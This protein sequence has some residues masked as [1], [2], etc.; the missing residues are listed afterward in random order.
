[1]RL[2]TTSDSLIHIFHAAALMLLLPLGLHAQSLFP[3]KKNK[4]WGLINSDGHIVRQPV[5]D[6]IGEFKQ[7]GYAIMQRNG[8]IG[9]LDKMGREV[10][11]P[12]Y[13]D[14][15][16]L[17]TA[18]VAVM[19]NGQWK[20][21]NMNGRTVLP[22]GYQQVEV[23]KGS[24]P[25]CLAYQLDGAWGIVDAEGRL[26]ASPQ[27]DKI[28]VLKNVPKHVKGFYFKTKKDNSW[29]VLLPSGR[30]ILAPC[31]DEIWVYNENLFF[32]K[33]NL[34]WGAVDRLG[35]NVLQPVYNHF[36]RLS[37]NFVKLGTPHGQAL[38]SLVYN[39]LVSQTPYDA[40][41]PFSPDYALCKK[42]RQLGLTGH[43]G[44][45]ALHTRYDEI[46]P[47]GSNT[48]RVSL[49]GQWGIVTLDD[50]VLI[51]FR[52]DYISPMKN[53]LCVIIKDHRSG[54]ANHRGQVLVPTEYD[55]IF[56]EDR[57]AK[58]YKGQQLSVFNF[59]NNG[60][61]QQQNSFN[62]HFTIN[63]VRNNDPVPPSWQ[64][65]QNPYQ[66]KKF[67]WFYS[68]K[69]DKWGLRRLDNGRVQIEPTFH[70]VRVEK[71]LGLTLV[72]I[73]RKQKLKFGQTSYRFEMTYG[74]VQNDTG[75]LVHEVDLLDIRLS[76]FDNGLPVARCIFTNGK[77][78][79]INRIGKVIRKDFT[80]VG[81][82]TEGL[83]RVGIKGKTS[84][85]LK[86]SPFTI[87]QLNQYLASQLPPVTLTDYTRY[88]YDM[89][90]L[91]Y[92][93]CDGCQW[94][95]VDTLGQLAV[96]PQ[97]DFARDFK[98]NVG[99]VATGNKWGMVNTK[100]KTLLRCEF[101]ELAFIDK[102]GNQVLH[103][104]K[105]EQKYGLIDTLG[106]LAVGVQYDEIGSFAEGRL[107]VKRRNLWGYVDANGLET[108]PCRFTQAGPFSEGLAA[109]RLGSK[110]GYID[111]N[112]NIE[113]PFQFTKAGPFRNGLAPAKK[114]GPRFGYIDPRGHWAI[115]PQYL[116]A[117]PFDRGV[118]RIV[119][120]QGDNYRHGLIN[121]KGQF[122]VRP[123]FA[124]ISPFDRHGLAVASLGGSPERFVLLNLNGEMVTSRSFRG[125]W[126]F[127][128]GLAKVKK[129]T[130]YGFINTKGQLVIPAKFTK[131]TDFSEGRAA[132]W[133]NGR[134][135]FIDTDGHIVINTE[136]SRC[137]DFKDGKAIVFKGNQRA[138]LIDKNGN[139]FIEPGI[140][141]LLEF[142]E[143]RGLVR[144]KHY[145]CYYITEQAR[146]YNGYYDKAGQ[147]QH[148]IAVVQI[149]GRWAIINQQGIKI[150]PPKYD[151]I[152]QFENGFAKVRIKG[153]NGLSNTRGE[154]IV[155]PDYEYISYAGE[156]LFRVE[157]GDKIG[158]FD[159]LGKW[160][161]G[162]Q[163]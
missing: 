123:K 69:Q 132:I 82:F 118:A 163:D 20:V 61:L 12:R 104:F 6:A 45:Q 53:G 52:Y 111:K 79:L 28:E 81:T 16:V 161:W 91:G 59:D 78:G 138:G 74:L 5:Y 41:Y 72:G 120:L 146:F 38:F 11:P 96:P 55:R 121:S 92:L 129:K 4:K 127:S 112:G 152:E 94:G 33:K 159:M 1:M 9:M 42:G 113:L 2:N 35:Q 160:V 77:H 64:S 108:V 32:Y 84:C 103:I 109:V 27:Y 133:L 87:G 154:L 49:N 86:N 62:K 125:I 25:P 128:D 58:A 98:N 117:N 67:E 141:Q 30:E 75:L 21:L 114:E 144:D 66:L 126:P 139:F 101:D 80:Y 149:N 60:S 31:A 150:I 24:R 97:Y 142:T 17:D 151:K 131:A 107:A 119:Q 51:P 130:G 73:E 36:S 99:I 135:G 34:K 76:D 65:D 46:Q 19:K 155:Q 50:V 124:S 147:F 39:Q 143:G 162:L 7:Y 68:P 100:G 43:C 29:G 136:F 15:K 89:D 26:I 90:R 56:L 122:V 106:Q 13:Q 10:V 22:P 40:I 140:N 23:L 47:Y 93:T 37:D 116:Q 148:G 71:N 137:M 83:A 153:F 48:F 110:W 102:T 57:L 3:I 105:K 115:P 158:Y 85:S 88:D 8:R 157:Q 44:E 95:Y 145:K 70:E 134:C 18:L 54:V 156:G 14:V 63:V